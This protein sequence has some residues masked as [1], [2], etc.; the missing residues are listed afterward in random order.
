MPLLAYCV[1]EV[2]A[3]AEKPASGVG[4]I[5]VE[6]L[7]EGGLRCLFSGLASQ[8]ALSRLPAVEAALAFHRTLQAVLTQATVIP[9]RFPTLVENEEELR[10]D[11]RENGSRY[12]E[13][14]AR[15][16]EMV[17]M[18]VRISVPEGTRAAQQP[19]SGREY[20]LGRRAQA[21]VVANAA[22]QFR[23]ATR[24]WVEEWRE[25]RTGEGVR[26][27]ALVRRE[28][29]AGFQEAAQALAASVPGA[30]MS[31]PWPPAAFL[32]PEKVS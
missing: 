12:A 15:L 4:G 1:M 22:Q 3:A 24:E 17:Q 16:R 29:V 9:F 27:Y 23:Q 8:E 13:A 14:L 30:R 20:L 6:E 31:G 25:H 18:E 7:Q 19:A 2:A 10:R 28:A 21:G 5:E 11:L 32:E 26:C